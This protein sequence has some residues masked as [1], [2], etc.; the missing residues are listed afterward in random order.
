VLILDVDAHCGGG[1]YDIVADDP[2]IWIVDISVNRF[3][4]YQSRSERHHLHVIERAKDYLDI[5]EL[6][7]ERAAEIGFDLMIYNAGMDPHED[8]GIGGLKGITSEVIRR[9]EEMVFGWARRHGVPVA[10]VLAGGYTGGDMWEER[11]SALHGMTVA[12]AAGAEMPDITA[13]EADPP[14]TRHMFFDLA[15]ELEEGFQAPWAEVP[16]E[17][18]WDRPWGDEADEIAADFLRSLPDDFFDFDPGAL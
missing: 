12:A 10:F 13:V 16:D 5:L 4:A 7:L 8:C 15:P 14:P 11:L 17:E 2:R 1:T 9:R 3:D 18:E 6:E